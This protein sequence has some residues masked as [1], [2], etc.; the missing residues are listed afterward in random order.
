MQYNVFSLTSTLIMFSDRRLHSYRRRGYGII[1][2]ESQVRG[3][4]ETDLRSYM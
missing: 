4:Q 2:E 3:G 1:I